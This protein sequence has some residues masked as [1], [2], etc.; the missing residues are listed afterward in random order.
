MIED[1]FIAMY[2]EMDKHFTGIS[3]K[4]DNDL[5]EVQKMAEEVKNAELPRHNIEIP[6]NGPE[7]TYE[8]ETE[9]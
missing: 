2:D 7:G 3:G 1:V 5:A 9:E 6:V 8:E 4:I